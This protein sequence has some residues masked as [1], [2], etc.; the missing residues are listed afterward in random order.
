MNLPELAAIWA[1]TENGVIGRDGDMPWYAPEDLAHFKKITGASPV[2]MG[3]VTW[4]SIPPRF[5]PLPGR[6]NILVSRS[7]ASVQQ[8]D[9]A[10]WVPNLP[11]AI[12]EGVSRGG[13]ASTLWVM[14]GASIYE[15]AL[16]LTEVPGILGGRLSRVERTVFEGKVSGD[17]YAPLLGNEWERAS[18]TD[19]RTSE[20]GYLLGKDGE[21]TE[22]TYR[23]E[24]W[25]R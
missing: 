4:E 6:L 24:S 21:R 20:K 16:A 17:A 1:Q 2:L 15:Q 22:L 8:K 3:R 14:G 18:A 10:L 19:S 7:V 25:R 13:H 11:T 23:F 5:R 12:A 9:G